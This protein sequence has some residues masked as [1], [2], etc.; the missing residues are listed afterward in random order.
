MLERGRVHQAQTSLAAEA[1]IAS[2][3]RRVENL[4]LNR[5]VSVSQVSA[6]MC[7][8][9]N[10]SDHVLEECSFLMTP[11]ESGCAQANVAYQKPINNL[12]ATTYNPGWRNHLN[13]S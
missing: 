9:C 2:L 10:A 4:E 1:K 7:N 3:I 11:I 8:G 13:F 12:Y 6:P 5:P